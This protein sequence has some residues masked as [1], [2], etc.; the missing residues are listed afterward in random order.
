MSTDMDIDDEFV[1]PLT[2]EEVCSALLLEHKLTDVLDALA[3]AVRRAD[4][5]PLSTF[6]A[7]VL[8]RAVNVIDAWPSHDA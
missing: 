4:R 6:E 3:G 5:R 1:A 7:D 8:E 2:L